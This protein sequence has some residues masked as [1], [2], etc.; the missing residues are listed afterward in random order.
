MAIDSTNPTPAYDPPAFPAPPRAGYLHVAAT[1]A[2]PTGP[3]FVRPHAA[4]S[5]LLAHLTQ[6]ADELERLDAVT[7]VSVYRAVLVPPADRGAGHQ[8]RYDVA[9][10]VETN[11]PE[12]LDDIGAEAPY[13]QMLAAIT[14]AASDVHVMAARCQRYLGDV[15]RDAPG[16]LFLFNHFI[17]DDLAATT[18]LW[19]QLAGWY[20]RKTGLDNSILLAPI[21]SADY[22]LVNHARFDKSLLR[23][24][25]EQFLRPSFHRYVR[26]NL[27]A[28]STVAMPVLYRLA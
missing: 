7:R 25:A 5:Q 19:E 9:V 17:A 27:R 28:H 23:L 8:A 1:I 22:V 24:A 2:P 21:G 13:Q 4:R 3:P 16:G 20:V 12:A 18:E 26:A 11:T 15:D 6:H 10:L 14:A